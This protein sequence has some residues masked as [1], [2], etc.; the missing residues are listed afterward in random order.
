LMLDGAP[1]VEGEKDGHEKCRCNRF[2]FQGRGGVE[3]SP[4]GGTNVW[5]SRVV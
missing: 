1:P 5:W 4:T 3:P 2:G